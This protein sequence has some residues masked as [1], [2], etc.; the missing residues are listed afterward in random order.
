MR[1]DRHDPFLSLQ[2]ITIFVQDQDRS[3]RF[4][5][6]QLGFRLV[7]DCRFESG[8]RWV[9]VGPPDGTA[10]LSLVTPERDS[11][12]AELIG[13]PTQ[14]V[15]VTEDFH[16]K[17]HEWRQRGVRFLVP[18]LRRMKLARGG[19]APNSD[20]A[21]ES[22]EESISVWGSVFA[23][24]KDVDGNSFGLVGIDEVTREIEKQRRA[25]AEKLEAERRAAQEL[26]IAKQVQ[27][28]LFPQKPPPLRTLEYSGA[29]IQARHVGGDYFDFIDL[30]PDRVAMVIG[31]ISGKGIAAALLMAS[32][33]ASLR[34]QCAFAL[35]QPQRLLRS[36]NQ[37]FHQNTDDNVFS[38]LFFAQYYDLSR[39]LRY[40]SCGHLPALLLRS[41][42]T[43]ERLGNVHRARALPG[44]GLRHRGA[45]ALAGGHARHLY[46]RHK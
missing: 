3:L 41:D 46:R 22:R 34:S 44:L 18:R 9:A 29:C 20:G 26:E 32:L 23:T 33:H 43:M 15:F 37:F 13:R 12:A 2:H 25:A 1:Q 31:D 27:A 8:R 42:S 35:D 16:A 28:R 5:V 14:I 21:S 40:A 30:G 24:F 19:N 38:T 36:V 7:S 4:F 10:V 45:A 39:L 11:K 6:D 17:F